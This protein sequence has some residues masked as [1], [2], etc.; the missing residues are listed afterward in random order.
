[1]GQL[2]TRRHGQGPALV[3]LHGLFGS[4]DNFQSVSLHFE[5]H[6]SVLR[7]DLPGHGQSPRL[8]TLSLTSMAEAVRE[9]LLA[10]DVRHCHLL[11]HSLGGKVA[12]AL[13]GDPDGL[14]IT[15]LVVVDIA[16]RRYPPSQA[17]VLDALAAIDLGKLESRRDA[18]RQLREQ[19]DDA[20][21][22]AFLLKSLYRKDAGQFDWRFD[23]TS[24]RRDYTL[25]SDA[26]EIKRPIAAP[27]LFIKG[28]NSD[29]L[30]TSDESV[31][32]AD[33]HAPQ[34]KEI[35]GAG[36]WPHAE[37]PALFTRICLEFIQQHSAT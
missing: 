28:G 32:R 36:H 20:G 6:L 19:I 29:Y 13:A 30:T 10:L 4:L 26:P 24:L 2:N 17:G 15:S 37:K 25:L 34:F 18:D 12:M 1:M 35:S 9:T 14:D 27:T 31:I 21:I 11:G 33:F 8:P 3:I 22:R 7:A 16:P 5:R 23:L